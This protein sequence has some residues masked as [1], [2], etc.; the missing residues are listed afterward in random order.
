[1]SIKE[2]RIT[3]NEIAS[4]KYL[5]FLAIAKDKGFPTTGTFL[6]EVDESKVRGQISKDKKQVEALLKKIAKAE[7]VQKEL[8][9]IYDAI[10]SITEQDINESEDG[11]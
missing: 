7:K 10:S 1:M 11:G 2:I 5:N 8:Q 6:L 9:A 4:P 3:P